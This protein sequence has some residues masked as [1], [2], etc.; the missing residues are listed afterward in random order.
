MQLGK[1]KPTATIVAQFAAGVEVEAIQHEGKIYLPA[2]HLG[3]FSGS[4]APAPRKGEPAPA[5]KPAASAP[6]AAAAPA[7]TKQY[8]KDELME[9]PSKDLEKILRKEFNINPDDYDGK[10]T[11]KKLRDLILDAQKNGG[12]EAAPAAA[13]E[14]EETDNSE[15]TKKVAEILGNFDSG[16]FSRKKA[17]AAIAEACGTDD[18]DAV[19]EQLDKFEEDGDASAEDFAETIVAA[20]LGEGGGSDEEPEGETVEAGD[21]E[22]GDKVAVWWNDDNQAWYTGVVDLVKRGKV[23]VKY[24]D[25]TDDVID[26]EIHTE[27]KRLA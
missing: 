10:N 2:I 27:I 20:L 12:S 26:P 9:M 4:E 14:T 25:G 24:D 18:T 7:K 15:T 1:V 17:I 13:E 3:E 8:T 6:A 22:V 19:S 5:T 16:K 21:L 23:H 11:N